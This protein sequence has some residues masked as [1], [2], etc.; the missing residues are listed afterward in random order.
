METGTGTLNVLAKECVIER[1]ESANALEDM[2]E[3]LVGANPVPT[4]ALDTELVN[5]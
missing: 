1:M 2:K 4:I 3:R 5:S